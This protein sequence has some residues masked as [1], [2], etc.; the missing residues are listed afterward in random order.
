M[1]GKLPKKTVLV[2][3]DNQVVADQVDTVYINNEPV[4]CWVLWKKIDNIRTIPTGS[5]SPIALAHHLVERQIYDYTGIGYFSRLLAHVC[6]VCKDL[7]HHGISEIPRIFRKCGLII[8]SIIFTTLNII[9]AFGLV[10]IS[11][12]IEPCFRIRVGPIYV[13]RFGH[14]GFELAYAIG[15]KEHSGKRNTTFYWPRTNAT[16]ANSQ[17]EI[18]AHRSLKIR[19]WFRLADKMH[20]RLPGGHRFCR[21]PPSEAP[22]DY[23][24]SGMCDVEGYISR[25]D[26]KFK[27]TTAE[28]DSGSEQLAQFG[29]SA[30]DKFVC[31]SIYTSANIN[32][33][34]TEFPRNPDISNLAWSYS[35]MSYR[36]VSMDAFHKSIF[37]LI[38]QGYKV[39][40][41]G[42]NETHPL[43]IEHE[44]LIDYASSGYASDFL[45]VWLLAHCSF[46]VTSGTGVV[47]IADGFQVPIVR[48]NSDR[49]GV[50]HK[51]SRQIFVP[52]PLL[53][54]A[55]GKALCLSEQLQHDYSVTAE[56][57]A[58]GLI[59]ADR[60][61]DEILAPI[62]EM[63]QRLNDTW[64]GTQDDHT[65][66]EKYWEIWQSWDR[67]SS[68]SGWI[69]PDFSIG[70][71]FLRD[72]EWYLQ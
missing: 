72:H 49:P 10:S 5:D 46:L 15:E 6:H 57:E 27:L 50:Q 31:Y 14:L 66:Q 56:Y 42:K 45:D 8:R 22:A 47:H 30:K 18:M 7:G 54:K 38:D 13:H 29:L 17:L 71:Q 28:I 35:A 26:P 1:L 67:F 52:K 43:N 11:R 51:W 55:T 21:I 16:W 58:H 53:H 20:R 40:R 2:N 65:R 23:N 24:W 36:E 63:H 32:Y 12:I 41:L 39:V 64:K 25:G 68:L 61:P 60:K 59:H 19:P 62:A 3:E 44:N 34:R 70:A 9:M 48:V 37:Y 4:D 69:C 33:Y